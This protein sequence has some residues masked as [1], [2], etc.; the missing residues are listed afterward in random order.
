MLDVAEARS[1]VNQLRLFR[2]RTSMK[3]PS[4]EN[5]MPPALLGVGPV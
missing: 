5:T 3:R 1:M 2:S 4:R